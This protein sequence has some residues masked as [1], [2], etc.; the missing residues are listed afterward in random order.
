MDYKRTNGVTGV[1]LADFD[2]HIFYSGLLNKNEEE[3]RKGL[4]NIF[5]INKATV[6]EGVQFDNSYAQHEIMLH[7]LAMEQ[8]T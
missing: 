3:I 1:N 7:I 5:S 2:T 4:E 6:K 8:N